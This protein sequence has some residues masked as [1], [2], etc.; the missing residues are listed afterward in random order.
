M[1]TQ[2]TQL[3][4][5]K[6]KGQ[7]DL[8]KTSGIN[9]VPRRGANF[10]RKKGEAPPRVAPANHRTFVCVSRAENPGELQAIEAQTKQR[11]RPARAV[12]PRPG[13]LPPRAQTIALIS[14]ARAPGSWLD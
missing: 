4:L 5:Y 3:F 10:P 11:G 9:I 8:T 13:P 14:R 1:L 6:K 2:L 7:L 12:P